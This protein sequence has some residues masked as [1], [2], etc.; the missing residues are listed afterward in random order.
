MA[1]AKTRK[2]TFFAWIAGLLNC[3]FMWAPH[4]VLTLCP[5]SVNSMQ[6]YSDPIIRH[7]SE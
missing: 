5:L 2:S 4:R 3:V 7:D 6:P 1:E